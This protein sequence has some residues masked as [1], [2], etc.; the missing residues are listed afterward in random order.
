MMLMTSILLLHLQTVQMNTPV[1]EIYI[2]LQQNH[3]QNTAT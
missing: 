1:L 2:I 3:L